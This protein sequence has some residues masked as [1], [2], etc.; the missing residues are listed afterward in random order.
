MDP[1]SVALQIS[2]FLGAVFAAAVGWSIRRNVQGLDDKL[3]RIETDVRQLSSQG[4]RHGESLAAGVQQFKAIER[5]LD[6]IED[7][8]DEVIAARASNGHSTRSRE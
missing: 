2:G 4:A 8:R 7:W 6:K 1:V 5:R 3:G